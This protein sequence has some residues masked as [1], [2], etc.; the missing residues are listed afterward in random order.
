MPAWEEKNSAV[1]KQLVL[2]F[3]PGKGNQGAQCL[4][5]TNQCSVLLSSFPSLI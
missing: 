3:Q 4:V 1:Y 5:V 2:V